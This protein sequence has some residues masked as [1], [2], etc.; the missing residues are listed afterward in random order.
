MPSPSKPRLALVNR[1]RP[2]PAD[3][4]EPW[5]QLY[6]AVAE[7]RDAVEQ[8]WEVSRRLDLRAAEPDSLTPRALRA[9]LVKAEIDQ[10][11]TLAA[12]IE[13]AM[14]RILPAASAMR[15][16]EPLVMPRELRLAALREAH[17]ALSSGPPRRCALVH[18]ETADGPQ[19]ALAELLLPG[20]LR[21]TLRATGQVLAESAPGQPLTL[22]TA[23]PWA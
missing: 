1:S 20:V 3:L 8:L 12:I 2:A 15:Q 14:L 16:G 19:T 21:V 22:S 5:P 6:E 4:W 18:I 13:A 17:Q 23:G 7:T 10:V 11:E 9:M